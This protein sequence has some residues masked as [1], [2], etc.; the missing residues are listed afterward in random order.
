MMDQK[1]TQAALER[2]GISRSYAYELAHGKRTPSLR[3]ARHIAEKTGI[4]VDVWQVEPIEREA[5]Q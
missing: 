5:T 3:L 2:I 1:D 4:D